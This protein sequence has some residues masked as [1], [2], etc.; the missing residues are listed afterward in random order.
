MP[1]SVIARDPGSVRIGVV[2]LFSGP[3]PSPF[4]V[5]TRRAAE[6]ASELLKAGITAR[7]AYV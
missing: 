5:H 1:V 7:V 2:T 4:G 6:L 3:A